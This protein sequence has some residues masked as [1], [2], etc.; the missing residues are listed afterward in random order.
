MFM[1][2]HRP[3]KRRARPAVAKAIAPD[4]KRED[5]IRLFDGIV[6]LLYGVLV[7]AMAWQLTGSS[8]RFGRVAQVGDQLTFSSAVASPLLPAAAKI[9]AR[10]L[11]GA[12][13]PPGGNC[14]LDVPAMRHGG[15][16]TVMAL[17]PD[18]VMLSWAGGA[19]A[20]GPAACHGGEDVLVSNA[21]YA[22]LA[23]DVAPITP[24]NPR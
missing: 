18:G 24:V 10:H 11:A 19:T 22:Q 6:P 3:P 21:N 7:G 13:A 15:A 5:H 9:P 1:L 14:L 4:Q 16:M 17:R 2:N 23:A 8:A 20:S 12:W